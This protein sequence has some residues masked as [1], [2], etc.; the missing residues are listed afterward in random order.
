MGKKLQYYI[1]WK[2]YGH[3]DDTWKPAEN[4]QHAQK[5]IKEYYDKH[6]QAIKTVSATI[7]ALAS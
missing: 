7:F 2:G 5:A 6:P 4:L 3:N 1:K